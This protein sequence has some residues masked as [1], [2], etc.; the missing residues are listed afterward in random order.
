MIQWVWLSQ[1]RSYDPITLFIPSERMRSLFD[2]WLDTQ[3]VVQEELTCEGHM[4]DKAQTKAQ[5]DVLH[6]PETKGRRLSLA[7]ALRR[8]EQ[9]QTH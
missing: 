5:T 7:E 4:Q 1:I 8:H 3:G 6:P 2:Q 9:E